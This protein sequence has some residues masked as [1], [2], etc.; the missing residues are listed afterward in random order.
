VNII[1]QS[2]HARYPQHAARLIEDRLLALAARSRAEQ[3]LVR[4][5]DAPE[6][7]PRFQVA[8]FVRLPGP[9]IHASACDHTVTVAAHKALRLVEAQFDAR[10]DRRTRRRRDALRPAAKPRPGRAW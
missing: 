9:D 7:S 3:A 1:L 5:V 4:L 2:R 10:A 8:I 6:A